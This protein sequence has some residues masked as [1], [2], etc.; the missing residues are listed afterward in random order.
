MTD[1]EEALSKSSNGS[2]WMTKAICEQKV[3]RI[4]EEKD[5]MK[6][7]IRKN[8]DSIN[9]L[10]TVLVSTLVSSVLSLLGILGVLLRGLI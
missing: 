3:K 7:S 6:K 8:A 2:A 10:H 9:K 1:R 5:D 4:D